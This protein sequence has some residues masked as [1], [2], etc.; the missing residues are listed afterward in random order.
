[1]KKNKKTI[2]ENDN[3]NVLDIKITQI[4]PNVI[5]DFAVNIING[6]HTIIVPMNMNGLHLKNWM[7]GKGGIFSKDVLSYSLNKPYA[8]YIIIQ[9]KALHCI[10]RLVSEDEKINFAA[11]KLIDGYIKDR[12]Y[13]ILKKLNNGEKLSGTQEYI[14][15]KGINFE[16]IEYI[17]EIKIPNVDNEL[18]HPIKSISLF[19]E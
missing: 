18:D 16:E 19:T 13:M 14:N 11:M 5:N 12:P 1:M 8:N 6:H 2:E 10:A 4:I 9:S 7:K 17:T 15:E 3:L